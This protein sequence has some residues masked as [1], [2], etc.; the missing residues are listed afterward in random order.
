MSS[1][2][3]DRIECDNPFSII[4]LMRLSRSNAADLRWCDMCEVQL[5]HVITVHLAQEAAGWA[6]STTKTKQKLS[7]TNGS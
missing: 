4:T 3:T 2:V 1:T 7:N 6:P 5:Q